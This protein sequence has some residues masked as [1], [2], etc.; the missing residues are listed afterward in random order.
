MYNQA[1]M[2][3]LYVQMYVNQGFSIIPV[4]PMSK[5]AAIKWDQYQERRPSEEEIDEWVRGYWSAGYNIAI[6]CGDVSGNLVVLDFDTYSCPESADLLSAFKFAGR[7]WVVETPSGGV[8]VYLRTKAPCPSFDVGARGKKLLEVRGIGRY[9]LAPPSVAPDKRSG[10]ARQY[11]FVSWVD[12]I[13]TITDH[14]PSK[15]IEIIEKKLGIR[16][17]TTYSGSGD[18]I[19]DLYRALGGSP[20]R[21][22]TPPCIERILEGLPEGMRNEGAIRLASFLLHMRKKSPDKVRELLRLWNSSMNTPPLPEREID[23][24]VDSILKHGYVYG[25]RSLRIFGCDRKRCKINPFTPITEDVSGVDWRDQ[26][27]R[28]RRRR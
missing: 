5:K 15:L 17:E 4:A 22:A 23:A 3:D 10:E 27:A 7:T 25:C 28:R 18:R 8:H 9:V 12:D 6:I 16:A 21:G 14:L 26:L 1:A 20:Y 24:V 13:P 19:L 11:K 2:M